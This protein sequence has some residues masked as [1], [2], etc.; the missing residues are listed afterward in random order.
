MNNELIYLTNWLNANKLSLNVNKTHYMVISPP[1]TKPTYTIKLNI[2]NIEI[3]SV[4][5]TK[6]L[7]VMLD[8]K[9]SW[10]PLIQYIS[11]K[12]SKNIGILSKARRYLE[13][14]SLIC[15]Y[16]SFIYPYIVYCI[17][18]WGGAN[19]TSLQHLVKIQKWAVRTISCKPKRTS[20]LP[21]FNA[22]QILNIKQIY[23]LQVLVFVYKYRKSK[24]PTVFNNFFTY[25]TSVHGYS[26]R[27]NN[28]FYPPLCRLD[29]TKTFIRYSGSFEWNS[30]DNK[31]KSLNGSVSSFKKHILKLWFKTEKK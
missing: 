17:S 11:T 6:F 29:L 28:N 7:G 5:H 25:T 18:V 9:L 22:L 3:H 21:L 1:R 8:N 20:S 13:V 10:I 31:T 14:K 2:N 26:T 24:L 19:A 23:T 12:L 16:Y 4:T 30:L 15:L 27:Q